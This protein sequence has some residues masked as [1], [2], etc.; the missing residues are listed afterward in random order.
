[1][2]TQSG[3]TLVELL[4]TMTVA[5]ILT[6]IAVPN[7]KLTFQNNRLISQSNELLG[8][9]LYAR[10]EAITLNQDITICA[11]SD[12]ATCGTAWASGWIV[13]QDQV[14]PTAVTDCSGASTILRAHAALT[15]GNTLTS[16]FGGSVVF[17][18]GGVITAGT[19][20]TFSLCDS[21]LATY[22]RSLWL[23][24]TGAPRLSTTAG[25][26]LDG[27]SMSC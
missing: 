11:S 20:G 7:F 9:L 18:S 6:A 15:G 22:G 13:C 25:K 3:F 23:T 5:A 1:M 26:R 21:R 4:V 19:A 8:S 10:S 12:G 17:Q 2:G 27:A 16:S 14:T 24:I